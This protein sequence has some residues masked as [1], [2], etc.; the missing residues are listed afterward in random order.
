MRAG[1]ELGSSGAEEACPVEA[2]VE[3]VD[4]DTLAPGGGVDEATVSDVDAGVADAPGLAYEVEA[5]AGE[6]VVVADAASDL[7]L[8][9]GGAGTT[10]CSSIGSSVRLIN[11]MTRSL[12]WSVV[13]R[14]FGIFA[15]S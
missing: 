14:K 13:R 12:A 15:W 4:A 11:A 7:E 2:V 6:E 1:V 8:L 5:V 10:Y 3:G 9:G